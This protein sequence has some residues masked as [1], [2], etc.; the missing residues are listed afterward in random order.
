MDRY[1]C[2]QCNA[3]PF[4]PGVVCT[5]IGRNSHSPIIIGGDNRDVDNLP[6]QGDAVE[7]WLKNERDYCMKDSPEWLAINALLVNYRMHAAYGLKLD[8]SIEEKE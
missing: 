1:R 2:S 7:I 4:H 5:G 3:G 6:E 8:E